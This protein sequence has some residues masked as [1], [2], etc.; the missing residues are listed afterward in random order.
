MKIAGQ[1]LMS[2]SAAGEVVFYK[3]ISTKPSNRE[4]SKEKELDF[5]N[6]AFK[7]VSAYLENLYK[8]TMEISSIKEA[9]IFMG[10]KLILDDETFKEYVRSMISDNNLPAK[11]ALELA[12]KHFSKIFLESKNPKFRDKAEDVRDV[13]RHLI[14]AAEDPVSFGISY[15][16]IRKEP[17]IL[18][19]EKIEPSSLMAF[20]SNKMKGLILKECSIFSHVAILAKGLNIPII[21]NIDVNKKLK[22]GELVLIDGSEGQ[23]V[24]NPAK[25]LLEKCM[26][27]NTGKLVSG[28]RSI[29]NKYESNKESD[30]KIKKTDLFVN[31]NTLDDLN[32]I[33]KSAVDGIGLFRTE[34]IYINMKTFPSEEQQLV[35]YKKLAKWK[36]E[37]PT[38]IR[39]LDIGSDKS[40]EYFNLDAETNPEMGYRGIRL[41]LG[42]ADVF[43]T[44]LRA[45][46]RASVYGD[47]YIMYPFVSDIGELIRAQSLLQEAADSLRKEGLRYALPR[48]GI[49]IETPSAAIMSKQ[50][51]K[52]VDFFSIGTNDLTA[53]TLGVD[54]LNPYVSDI[55]NSSH[56]AVM[57]LIKL[58]IRNAH[59]AGIPVSI[60]G[61][62]AS[63]M[64]MTEK[65]LSLG[66]DS[67]SVAP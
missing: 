54:R 18:V 26:E 9:Q 51:A 21:T 49:M 10:Q 17:Y 27:E 33:D 2:G 61:E 50:L 58:T 7:C 20:Y 46:L 25:E 30:N 32:H 15:G 14:N 5:L 41:A 57:E 62:L 39:T 56:P 24:T 67:L 6:E 19:A 31:I 11:D 38:I 48:Q 36:E 22:E 29:I 52:Y 45:L 63:D 12:Y 65:L 3:H 40:V 4:Y 8:K 1:M 23:V 37:S 53:L 35:I 43:K 47:L 16:N 13:V 28:I 60:C 59:S 42:R 55:Y 64:K 44:Q 34:Y 66:I